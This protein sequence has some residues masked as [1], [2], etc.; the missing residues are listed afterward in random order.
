MKVCLIC[1]QIAAWGKIG[2]FGVTTRRLG[3]GL[4]QSG[5]EVHAVIPIRPG[6]AKLEILDGISVYGQSNLE[7]FA[8]TTIY[9]QIDA[10]IYHVLEPNIC[11]FWAQKAMPNRIHRVSCLDPRER[12]D[13]LTELRFA[14]WSR[15]MKYP[16]QKFYEDSRLVRKSVRSAHGVYVWENFLKEKAQRLYNLS[17]PPELFPKPLLIPGGPFHKSDRPLCVFLGRFDPRKRPEIF[18]ELAKSMHDVDFVAI[19]RAHDLSYQNYL[20]KKYFN[21]PNLEVAGYIDPFTDD[22]LSQILKRAWVLIHPAAREALPTALQEASVHEVA[23]LAN[24][25]PGGYV[26]RFGRV[27]PNNLGVNGYKKHLRS[28]IESGAW[29]EKGKAGRAY[30]LEHHTFSKSIAEH[31]N[32]Y[33]SHL[34]K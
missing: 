31:I 21:L 20:E 16:L 3:Y 29:R 24:V 17:M 4:V 26:S 9:K 28:L 11:G 15:R 25:N 13:W 7:V 23:I 8:G 33:A 1:N 12:I 6:Q 32:A 34:Q 27:V 18:F 14:T 19:G 5:I 30:N 2:G 10:D 22:R